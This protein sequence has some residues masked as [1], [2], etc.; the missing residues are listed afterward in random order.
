MSANL[1]GIF[2][3]LL[4]PL[5]DKRMQDEKN[6]RDMIRYYLDSRIHGFTALGEVS[7]RDRLTAKEKEDNLRIV[8]EEAR[9]KV[10]IVVGT[11][12]EGTQLAIEASVRAEEAGASAVMVAP[13]KNIKLRDD[14]IF[15]HY[16]A[17][18]DAIRIPIVVQDEPESNHPYLSPTLIGRISTEIARARY[19]KLEDPPTPTKI[20]TVKQLVGDKMKIFGAFYGRASLWEVERGATGIMT[21]S[22]T[23][24]YLVGMWEA[25]KNGEKEKAAEIFFS[26]SA[27]I[28]FYS[29]M[30]VAVRKETLAHR[31]V[32]R[33]GK[34]KMPAGELGDIERR[35]LSELITWTENKLRTMGLSPHYFGRQG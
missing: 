6:L 22:A 3:M 11:S 31:G 32:I 12:Q 29:D 21:S 30:S 27:L 14:A 5:N 9:G 28:N 4:T 8:M 2:I 16:A 25:L 17:I 35:E 1:A 24:E 20:S 7:E 13:P 34:M 33:F 18:N 26:T 10:P 19:L 15:Q 23:P